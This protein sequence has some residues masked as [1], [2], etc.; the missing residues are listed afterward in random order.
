MVRFF[1]VVV[2]ALLACDGGRIGRAR[3]VRI[4]EGAAGDEG[5]DGEEDR[6]ACEVWRD[7]RGR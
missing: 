7:S 6:V 5:G 3:E 1:E 4:G 2:D